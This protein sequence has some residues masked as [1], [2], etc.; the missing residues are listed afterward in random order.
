MGM[1][2]GL[3]LPRIVV[4]KIYS[5]FASLHKNLYYKIAMGILILHKAVGYKIPRPYAVGEKSPSNSAVDP[6]Q[7]FGGK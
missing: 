2:P 1:I 6:L 3:N 5:F 4:V 7:F